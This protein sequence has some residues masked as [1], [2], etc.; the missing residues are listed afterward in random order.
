MQVHGGRITGLDVAAW[1]YSIGILCEFTA[2]LGALRW[3][4]GAVDMGFLFWKFSSCLNITGHRLLSEKVTR[5]HI[6][7]NRP[8]LNSLCACARGC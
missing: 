3:P 1:S 6:R 7:L 8:I 4:V 5:A 2:F